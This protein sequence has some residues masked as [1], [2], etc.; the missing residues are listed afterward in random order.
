MSIVA[1]TLPDEDTLKALYLSEPLEL[2][3][4]YHGVSL[5]RRSI[6]DLPTRPDTILIYRLPI[7]EYAKSNGMPVR[8]VVR[9]VLVHEIGHHFGFSDEDMEA[10][11]RGPGTD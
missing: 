9:H 10:I 11:E 7:L 5:T 2:L 3:G 1:S 6:Y 8:D 4:L